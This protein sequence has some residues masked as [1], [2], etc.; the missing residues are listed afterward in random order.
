[1]LKRMCLAAAVGQAAAR[2][3]GVNQQTGEE[4]QAGAGGRRALT[5]LASMADCHK[6]LLPEFLHYE[7]LPLTSAIVLHL[8]RK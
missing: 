8:A 5:S 3:A 4:K 1:M 6:F 7:P 2:T